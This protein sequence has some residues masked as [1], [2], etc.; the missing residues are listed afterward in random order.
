MLMVCNSST[1]IVLTQVMTGEA[2]QG[3]VNSSERITAPN[4][5]LAKRIFFRRDDVTRAEMDIFFV[6]HF[7][8]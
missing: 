2:K 3:S 1:P 8:I 5:I 4:A 7:R 6:P